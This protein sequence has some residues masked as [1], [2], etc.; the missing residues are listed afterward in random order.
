[1]FTQLDRKLAGLNRVRVTLTEL[2]ETE[3][4]KGNKIERKWTYLGTGGDREKN[5]ES[6]KTNKSNLYR[7]K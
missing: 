4:R 3:T 2:G 6:R 5:V 1:M 7:R